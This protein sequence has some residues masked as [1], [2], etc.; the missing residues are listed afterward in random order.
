MVKFAVLAL[1][2]SVKL[3][4]ATA[5]HTAL[6]RRPLDAR[7]VRRGVEEVADRRAGARLRI[8]PFCRSGDGLL[9]AGG[10]GTVPGVEADRGESSVFADT[11]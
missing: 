11:A 4:L 10:N 6:P 3:T 7:P 5:D 9:V 2:A 8:A 1:A